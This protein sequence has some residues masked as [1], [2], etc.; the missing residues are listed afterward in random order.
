MS[1][2]LYSQIWNLHVSEA[3]KTILVLVKLASFGSFAIPMGT[4]SRFSVKS[5]TC[6]CIFLNLQVWNLH[7][8]VTCSKSKYV[9]AKLVYSRHLCNSLVLSL[10]RDTVSS[11]HQFHEALYG[12]YSGQYQ[13][14]IFTIY[15]CL[16]YIRHITFSFHKM[17][18][19]CKHNC[20]FIF[21]WNN[22]NLCI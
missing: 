22:L 20:T 9:L 14:S 7:I 21:A 11:R 19:T 18:V 17:T 4:L 8:K 3:H 12:W 13:V 1:S 6:T 2:Y 5:H 15:S 16:H 10:K